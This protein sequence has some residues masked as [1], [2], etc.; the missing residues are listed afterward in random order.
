MQ[1]LLAPVSL[2]W[3]PLRRYEM[4]CPDGIKAIARFKGIDILE[5]STVLAGGALA[6]R[7]VG[8]PVR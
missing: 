2:D 1:S 8:L 7:V 5:C 4:K 6:G 3:P